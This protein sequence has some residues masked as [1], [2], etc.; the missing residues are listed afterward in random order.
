MTFK[1][2]LETEI[3]ATFYIIYICMEHTVTGNLTTS[4]FSVMQCG[5]NSL[6]MPYT[7]NVFNFTTM[8]QMPMQDMV[9]MP[10]IAKN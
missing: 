1:D 7:I 3:Y 2:Q 8:P 4:G 9:Q 10:V 5:I 6:N